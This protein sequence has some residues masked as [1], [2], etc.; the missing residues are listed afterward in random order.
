MSVPLTRATTV[1][2][3]LEADDVEPAEED[4]DEFFEQAE[5]A[6]SANSASAA[7]AA[8][9]AVRA[10]GAAAG[11]VAV[12]SCKAVDRVGVD[13]GGI[14]SLGDGMARFLESDAALRRRRR[15]VA[16]SVSQCNGPKEA[17]FDVH[18]SGKAQLTTM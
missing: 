14:V 4:D 9:V 5:T 18:A 15:T 6:G 17:D 11:E 3:A 10:R 7:M 13:R 8:I 16:Q 1:S 12:A 2:E